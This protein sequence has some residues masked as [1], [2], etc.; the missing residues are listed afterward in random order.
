MRARK[1]TDRVEIQKATVLQD[2]HG[3]STTTFEKVNESWCKV[4]TLN[5]QRVTDLGLN[6]NN[7]V[8]EV[9]LRYR[10]DVK[11]SV[12]DTRLV[13]R[14]VIFNVLRVEQ[15]DIENVEIKITAASNEV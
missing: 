2:G 5:I 7:T 8:I 10:D 3:G 4:K 9:N 12:K 13:Y 1:Y 6:D 15:K 11:Y 14:D